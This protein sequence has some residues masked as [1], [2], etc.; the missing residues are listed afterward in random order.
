M[1]NLVGKKIIL[2]VRKRRKREEKNTFH[3]QTTV[4]LF[5]LERLSQ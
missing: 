4:K 5:I 2:F 3:I 1:E